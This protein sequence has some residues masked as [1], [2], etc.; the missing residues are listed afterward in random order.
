MRWSPRRLIPTLLCLLLAGADLPAAPRTDGRY[1]REA[2]ATDHPIASEVAASILAQGGTAADAAAAAMLALGV[3]SPASSGF[4][5]GGFALYFRASDRSTTFLDF[6]ETAPAAATADLFERAEAEHPGSRPSQVGGLSTGVPGEPAGIERLVRGFGRLGLDVV[7]RPAIRL[8]R[9]G[10]APSAYMLRQTAPGSLVEFTRDPNLRGFLRGG[11]LTGASRMR[12]PGLARTLEVFA[13]HGADGIY[14]GSVARRMVADIAR[15]GGIVSLADLAAYRVR[16][17]TPMRERH[18]GHE[19]VTAP[20][21]SAGGTTLLQSLDFLERVGITA[22]SSDVEFAHAL[23]ESWKGPYLD[24]QAAFGDPDYVDVP[25]ERLIASE[26]RAARAAVFDAAR[27]RPASA[28]AMPLEPD[29][30]TR[31]PDGG[32]TTHLCIVD[33]E[34]NVAS[35][36]TTV[37]L[38]FGARYTAASVLMNDEMDDFARGVG[39]ANAFG[40]VGGARNLPGPGRRPVSS[41][42][43]TLVFG[44]DGR[45]E[46]CIGAAGGSRIPTATEQVALAILLRGSSPDRAIAAPRIHHQAAPA[47]VFSERWVP[48]APEQLEGLAARGHVQDLLDNV[49]I[50]TLVRLL[51]DGT[52]HAAADPR[53]GGGTAGR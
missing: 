42:S 52:L 20:P 26:R 24:R 5:G 28:Y 46:L 14:R 41:M 39:L 36:T 49:A 15:N 53:K 2:V 27:A 32:G 44:P 17:R 40:L 23:V 34:G 33:R 18:F 8:A 12:Q 31:T 21:P 37:N 10:V 48:A 30:A 51:P 45:P 4:G 7:T 19:W 1:A 29:G 35:I 50:V 22:A 9:R 13:R 43:P 25:L 16:E 11:E 3:V 38:W 47:A 6:R